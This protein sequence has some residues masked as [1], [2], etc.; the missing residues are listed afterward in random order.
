MSNNF[1]QVFPSETVS[2]MG[3]DELRRSIGRTRDVLRRSEESRDFDTAYEVQIELCY[4]L[5]EREI[6]I[7]RIDAHRRYM[8]TMFA[9]GYTTDEV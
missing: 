5:R 9:D 2:V 6:R 4:L 7:A 8:Q 3:D 1:N